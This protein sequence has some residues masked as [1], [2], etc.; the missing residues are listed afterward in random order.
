VTNR[1]VEQLHRAVERAKHPQHGPTDKRGESL[2]TRDYKLQLLSHESS[3]IQIAKLQ[4]RHIIVAAAACLQPRGRQLPIPLLA[5]PQKQLACP[6]TLFERLYYRH[7]SRQPTHHLRLASQSERSEHTRPG[8]SQ[9]LAQR[10]GCAAARTRGSTHISVAAAARRLAHA[11]HPSVS[12][13]HQT[14]GENERNHGLLLLRGLRLPQGH[15]R[16]DNT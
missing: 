12:R 16:P 14:A 6:P 2:K 11:A 5:N 9:R 3:I 4:Q 8:L 10:S 15:A 1:T 13:H 7:W